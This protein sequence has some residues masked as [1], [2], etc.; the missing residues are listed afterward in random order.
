MKDGGGWNESE[1]EL[2]NERGIELENDK[3]E[4]KQLEKRKGK[5]IWKESLPVGA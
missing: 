5:A 2:M 4:K 3:K 1:E